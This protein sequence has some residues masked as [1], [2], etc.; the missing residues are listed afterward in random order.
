[1]IDEYW[2]HLFV[3]GDLRH[4]FVV[5]TNYDIPKND[6]QTSFLPWVKEIKRRNKAF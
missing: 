4:A 3:V 1:M 2:D 5:S 6:W